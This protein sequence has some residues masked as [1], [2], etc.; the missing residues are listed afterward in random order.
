MATLKQKIEA[1][2]WARAMLA[3]N[4]VPAPDAVEYGCTCIRLLWREPK[5]FLRIDIDE[6]PDFDYEK[7]VYPDEA[8]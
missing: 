1:E 3:D 7:Q 5:L 8:A 6:D 4:D 2:K